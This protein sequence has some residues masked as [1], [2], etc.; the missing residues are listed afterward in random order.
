MVQ[1]VMYS[2]I[3]STRNKSPCKL[4]EALLNS[5]HDVTGHAVCCS[6]RTVLSL[7]MLLRSCIILISTSSSL[8]LRVTYNTIFYV[9]KLIRHRSKYR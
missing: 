8:D 3:A 9:H 5:R 4:M 2:T 7:C 1:H 6:E